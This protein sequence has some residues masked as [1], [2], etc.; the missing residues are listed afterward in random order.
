MKVIGKWI[1]IVG[2]AVSI[3]IGLGSTAIAEMTK[4]KVDYDHSTVGFQVVHMVVSKTNGKFTEYS[5]VVEMDPDAKE[6]KTIEAVIQ[7]ASVTTDH[8][9][10]DDHLRSPDFFDVQKFP[11]MTYKMKSYKKSGDQ[12]TALGDLTLLGVTKEITLVG[13]FN[14]VAQ[15]PWGNTR[16]GFT[17]EGTIN[18]KDYGMKF[19]KL[20]DSGGMLVGDEVKIKL[21]IEVIKEKKAEKVKQKA[22]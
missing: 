11:T 5:G 21:E 12:Y 14:G 7:T 15:D 8:Q 17:A 4:W 1:V 16:A 18:R 9:K 22:E 19:S 2:M 10:R 13:M 20:L 3:G 6:F